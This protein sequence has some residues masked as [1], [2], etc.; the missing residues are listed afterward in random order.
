[1]GDNIKNTIDLNSGN[2]TEDFAVTSSSS[3]KNHKNSNTD[4]S[5]KVKSYKSLDV[6]ENR[7]IPEHKNSGNDT[8][9]F[10]VTSSSS[11]NDYKSNNTDSNTS[12][13][14]NDKSPNVQESR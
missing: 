12:N 13:V 14:N 6:Q 9:D 3:H 8:I 5:L 11:Y 10:T 7:K 2:S 1:M 4:D